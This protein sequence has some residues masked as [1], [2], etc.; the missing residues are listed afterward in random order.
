MISMRR[1]AVAC[2]AAVV[3]AGLTAA[4]VSA[5]TPTPVTK[6][7][8]GATC[9]SW[10]DTNSSTVQQ[11]I[12]LFNHAGDPVFWCNNAGG[13]WVGNDKFG[14]T[15][16]NTATLAAYL[17]TTNGTNGQLVID[18][19]SLT[20]P[21]IEF[22]T[23]LDGSTS[24]ST[25]AIRGDQPFARS[26]E[27]GT[28][29]RGQAE[30]AST[31][32]TNCPVG[33]PCVIWEDTNTTGGQQDIELFDHLGNPIFWCN[34]TGGCWVGNDR[35]GVTGSS[36]FNLAA[37]LS[38]TNGTNGE[39]VIDG[40]VLTGPDIAF[41]NCLNGGGG[42]VASCATSAAAA[43]S[44][45][46][47]AAHRSQVAPADTATPA[48]STPVTPC[49]VGATCVSWKDTNTTGSQ[50]D[51][52]L[53]NHT[54]SLIYW[55]DNTGGCWVHNDKLGVTGSSVFNLA[56]YLS[57]TNGTNGELVIDGQVLTGPD[58]AFVNCLDAGGTVAACR[59]S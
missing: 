9:V 20:G 37:Y 32:V 6:C 56:A 8:V 14:V 24:C 31:P 42:S 2:A 27:A 47:L 40:H 58:I 53:L 35:L 48:A 44:R 51:I 49:P 26:A 19:K 30:A 46:G 29:A 33:Q 18:G 7:P 41:V 17:S 52:E 3:A 39:L 16:S 1:V 50:K 43:V 55:C 12:E 11:D 22:I 13:C 10:K 25:A 21:G 34:N 45:L 54:G 5:A 23:C 38:T 15:G 57:T 59:T 28:R 4:P 36:V